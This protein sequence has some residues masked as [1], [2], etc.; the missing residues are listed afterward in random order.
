MIR[1]MSA[2]SG[3]LLMVAAGDEFAEC[4][5]GE[6]IAVEAAVD[7]VGVAAAVALVDHRSDLAVDG[8]E[9]LV[10]QFGMKRETALDHAGCRVEL[11][12]EERLAALTLVAFDALVAFEFAG[13]VA[14]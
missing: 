12:R 1:V 10:G 2:S 5:C 8:V 4:F 7:E 13:E 3:R 9:D 11:A 6:S 14:T